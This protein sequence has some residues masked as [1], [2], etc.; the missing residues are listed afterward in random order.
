MLTQFKTLTDLMV[1]FEDND[2]AVEHFKALRWRNGEFC[3][4][5][6]YDKVYTLKRQGQYRCAG[7][8]RNF[9]ITVGTIF[10]NTKLPLRIW[11]GAVWLITNHKKG[12]ASTT[13]ATDLGIT[14]KSAWFVLHRLRHA[15]RT[16]SFNKP[17]KGTV[18]IDETYVGGKA[19]NRHGRRSGDGG[20]PGKKTPV[21]GAKER[22]GFT[23]ARVLPVASQPQ[24][25]GFI[26]DVVS[27]KAEMLVTDSA[28]GLF[29][30]SRF[31]ST[32]NHQSQPR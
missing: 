24:M 18:E 32:R 6:G 5:C 31:R 8:R 9:S 14:Q 25:Q 12:I 13:L 10:E 17:L 28:S 22:D 21:I 29:V 26:H 20:G 16:N 15:A 1:A 4:R 27:K 30:V 11:F 23:V 19:R 7:C 2:V 3:P